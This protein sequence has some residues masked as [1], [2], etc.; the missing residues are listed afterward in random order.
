[1]QLS[2]KAA[3]GMVLMAQN[4]MKQEGFAGMFL[5]RCEGGGRRRRGPSASP[6]EQEVTNGFIN[7]TRHQPHAHSMC[8]WF[9]FVSLPTSDV[10]WHHVCVPANHAC[11]VFP[12]LLLFPLSSF[13]STT[14]SSSLDFRFFKSYIDSSTYVSVSTILLILH[15]MVT[16]LAPPPLP[17]PQACTADYPRPLRVR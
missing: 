4:I 5:G 13:T 1:M 7:P 2:G 8:F 6:S 17:P 16:P 12:H 14:R 3:G 11:N 9:L 10:T 15:L